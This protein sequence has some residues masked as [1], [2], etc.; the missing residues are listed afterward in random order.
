[1]NKGSEHLNFNKNSSAF[2]DGI[3]Q[4]IVKKNKR[5]RPY[6]SKAGYCP[7]ANWFM[8]NS[9]GD[10]LVTSSMKLYQGIGNGVEAELVRGA[11]RSGI[12]LGTQVKLPTP[13]GI[14]LGGFIDMIVNINN[15][16]TL[17]EVKTCTAIP[18]KI[19]PEH[20]A[21][22]AAYW[23]FSGLDNVEVLYVSRKVQNFPDP[24]PLIKSFKFDSSE[25]DFEIDNVFQTLKSY[26]L[27]KA[28][29]RP[30]HFQKNRDCLY[31]DFSNKCWSAELEFFLNNQ[32]MSR[33]Q[34]DALGEKE[35]V[36]SKRL[37]FL[38]KT[39][40]NCRTSVPSENKALLEDFIRIAGRK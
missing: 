8:G 27:K 29:Q 30:T 5:A 34:S 32:E 38:A 1:M 22:A 24:T 28:P 21:Q 7:T 23:I 40:Q 11:E 6:A 4:E 37:D 25:H 13:Q 35:N 39:L 18:T 31:C 9:D 3:L 10:F 20:A 12:L 19:K 36:L 26:N 14:D 17:I 16:P 2:W 33:L 15:H